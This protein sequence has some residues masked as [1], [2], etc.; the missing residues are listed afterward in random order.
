MDED[1]EEQPKQ[2]EDTPGKYLSISAGL[3]VCGILIYYFPLYAGISGGWVWFFRVPSYILY[4]LGFLG[5]LV[6][7]NEIKKNKFT[8]YL[9]GAIF[10][11]GI[12]YLLHWITT[13][14]NVPALNLILRIVGLVVIC[15]AAL[16]FFYGLPNLF[17]SRPKETTS[18]G[19]SRSSSKSAFAGKTTFENVVRI[20]VALT[21]L[22]AA[23]IPLIS[24]WL[25]KP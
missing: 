10:L 25:G 6:G 2:S 21:S 18:T 11:G 15:I 24:K 5:A 22:I 17:P 19:G 23:L 9:A 13:Q 12:A 8:G 7:L 3:V 14:F 1:K 20:L 4:I 16:L